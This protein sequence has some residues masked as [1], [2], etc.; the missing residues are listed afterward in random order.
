M[1]NKHII[2]SLVIYFLTL[3]L[4]IVLIV[5]AAATGNLPISNL[6]EADEKVVVCHMHGM[7]YQQTI[8]IDRADLADHLG[9]GDSEGECTPLQQT[10][11]YTCNGADADFKVL[12]V[13]SEASAAQK[14]T[15]ERPFESISSALQYAEKMDFPRVELQIGPGVYSDDVAMLSRPTRI[16]GPG[17]NNSPSAELSLS[18]I[19]EG[20]YEIGIQGVV[21]Q[22]A[23]S[24]PAVK[25]SDPDA[26]T[27]I[28]DVRFE[29]VAG[30]AV[31]QT[32]GAIYI[33]DG[34]FNSTAR[35]SQAGSEDHMT[36][37]AIVLAGGVTGLINN[38]HVD[39]SSGSGL[40]VSGVGTSVEI[41]WG[42][43]GQSVLENGS[44][45]LGALIV[46]GGA[47]LKANQLMLENNAVIGVHVEG[48][49]TIVNLP[50][51]TVT[52]TQSL[53]DGTTTCG[54]SG[55]FGV[56]ASSG[57]ILNITGTSSDPFIISDS[58]LVG[59][60]LDEPLEITLS[61]GTVKNNPIGLFSTT[62]VDLDDFDHVL[63]V[64]NGV[65]SDTPCI[66][67]PSPTP[68]LACNDGVDNDE[69]GLI[70][71]A[72]PDCESAIVCQQ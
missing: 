26:N 47:E 15:V 56:A 60:L 32:G 40:H 29:S 64:D 53:D 7:H 37:T 25:V 28:C 72:D 9:H 22:D 55:G 46:N 1:F 14:G 12:Y 63:W 2:K 33:E 16:V 5:P 18:I 20:A 51:L 19:N 71:C 21:F 45:C 54:S 49:D 69:D 6:S 23:S 17:Q 11:M 38:I 65:N 48:D 44:G 10:V 70:D 61:Y 34:V 57:S 59:L 24:G 8:E 13:S 52:S 66:G 27:A 39:G 43:S 67:V 50:F 3:L 42:G 31:H 4:L 30:H 58:G 36:G 35:E 62:C 41:D 68:E